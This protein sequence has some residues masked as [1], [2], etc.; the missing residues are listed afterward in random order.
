MVQRINS[1]RFER[2]TNQWLSAEYC[3][4]VSRRKMVGPLYDDQSSVHSQEIR[5]QLLLLETRKPFYH[6]PTGLKRH[7]LLACFTLYLSSK[8]LSSRN[9]AGTCLIPTLSKEKIDLSIRLPNLIPPLKKRWRHHFLH[10]KHLQTR[11]AGAKK[12][13][14]KY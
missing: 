13:T 8:H 9:A 7:S 2:A 6:C 14:G 3:I 1:S 10:V 12:S 5:P 11:L 4:L